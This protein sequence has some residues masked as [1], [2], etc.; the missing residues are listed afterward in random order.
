M[1]SGTYERPVLDPGKENS[2]LGLG[3]ISGTM[4]F[5]V[6]N[7]STRY[8]VF[9]SGAQGGL[10]VIGGYGSTYDNKAGVYIISCSN[11]G[12]ISLP[13]IKAATYSGLTITPLSNTVIEIVNPGGYLWGTVLMVYGDKPTVATTQPT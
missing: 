1:A 4:R 11:S 5:E 3:G 6:P 9:S 10:L 7:S 2:L 12:N 13:V 8:L